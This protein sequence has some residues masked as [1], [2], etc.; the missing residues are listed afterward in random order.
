VGPKCDVG[1]AHRSVQLPVQSVG[2]QGALATVT[3]SPRNPELIGMQDMPTTE[4]VIEGLTFREARRPP[5][6]WELIPKLGRQ[7][8]QRN[9][10]CFWH[11]SA[12]WKRRLGQ[13]R[14]GDISLS[15]STK[16]RCPAGG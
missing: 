1:W 6:L 2:S 10:L 7:A 3:G 5:S 4:P 14:M 15:R 12:L 9:Q 8:K 11:V 13:S 16:E